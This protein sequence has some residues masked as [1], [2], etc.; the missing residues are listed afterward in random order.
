[1]KKII[2]QLFLFATLAA[3]GNTTVDDVFRSMPQ[4]FLPGFSELNREMLLS[5][6]NA[7]IAYP[8]GEI[9]KL[10]H[11][12]DFLKIR[13]SAIGTMQIRLL[14]A[15]RRNRMIIGM[16]RTV[17]S[18]ACDSHIRFYSTN[19]EK[20]DT[21]A[22]LPD[23]SASIFFDSLQKEAG[24]YKYALSLSGISPISAQFN[25]NNT[26]MTLTFNYR[27]HLPADMVTELIPFLQTDTVVLQ[28]RNG[29]FR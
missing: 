28:W 2:L 23:I 10:Q 14:P 29:S 7:V 4:R 27:Q 8:I 25:G 12:T 20:L 26:D 15:S 17:C 24:N 19:W 16:I 9:E 11:T 22:L 3:Y 21:A 13:T 6:E 5:T 18:N 1:M